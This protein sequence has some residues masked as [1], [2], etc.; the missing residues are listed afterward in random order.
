MRAKQEHFLNV[1]AAVLIA[2]CLVLIGRTHLT[3]RDEE[4]SLRDIDFALELVA[5]H[6]RG[7]PAPPYSIPGS[8][9]IMNCNMQRTDKPFADDTL[10]SW[11]FYPRPDAGSTRPP[12]PPT[13]TVHAVLPSVCLSQ[14]AAAKREIV[15]TLSPGTGSKY[16]AER[17]LLVWRKLA[18]D[19]DWPK[20]PWLTI[21]LRP[22]GKPRFTPAGIA[23]ATGDG[24]FKLRLR[25]PPLRRACVY[26]ARTIAR[27]PRESRRG[28]PSREEVVRVLPPQP[29]SGARRATEFDRMLPGAY[30]TGLSAE[31][32]VA[33]PGDVQV[34]FHGT[35]RRLKGAWISLRRWLPGL[36]SPVTPNR[37][38]KKPRQVF[39]ARFKQG[40]RLRA[41]WSGRI[42]GKLVVRDVDSE[43]LLQGLAVE[44]R[45]LRN[46]TVKVTVARLK[47]TA[48]GRV[49][50]LDM[51]SPWWPQDATRRK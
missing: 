32:S 7:N 8:A 30:A 2:T 4:V 44:T 37:K 16:C 11:K 21:H 1:L 43:L 35:D 17:M 33:N 29:E 10:I 26:R 36:A 18:S 24:N 51:G 39:I 31:V 20:N 34:R 38:W 12:P 50:R 28:P 48:T 41:K 27:F 45:R 40:D 9:S 47:D 22:R 25:S 19:S 42:G 3:P 15:L 49:I 6:C 13:S 46:R 23:S 5:E 14:D